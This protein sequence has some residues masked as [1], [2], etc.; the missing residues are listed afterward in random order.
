MTSGILAITDSGV[1][2]LLEDHATLAV[3]EQLRLARRA[4]DL[5]G[6]A[7]RCAAEPADALRALD[8]LTA[9]G[10]A[11]RV[12][13]TR[14]GG[15]RWKAS[16][17]QIVI[18]YDPRDRAEAEALAERIQAARASRVSEVV[19]RFGVRTHDRARSCRHR[20]AL[21]VRLA[22]EDLS[23]LTRRIRAV[24]DFLSLV[25]KRAPAG[26]RAAPAYSNHAVHVNVEPLAGPVLPQPEVEIVPR[27]DAERR[28]AAPGGNPGPRGLSRREH[29]VAVAMS[30]GLTRPQIAQALGVSTNT[31]GTL[32]LRIYRKLGVRTRLELAHAMQALSP[33]NGDDGASTRSGSAC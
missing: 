32:S 4:L 7:A 27:A 22:P 19:N 14:R 8:R 17:D 9:A 23:E 11:E 16:C 12:A 1:R 13:T 20:T 15:V 24:H 2:D 6:I 31:V 30:R 28:D 21:T 3:W 5:R 10:L 18:A 29:D 26:A 33:P 25:S